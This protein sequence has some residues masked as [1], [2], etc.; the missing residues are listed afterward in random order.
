M[1]SHGA[2]A[3]LCNENPRIILTAVGDDWEEMKTSQLKLG[4]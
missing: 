1:F 2:E 4:V 3:R